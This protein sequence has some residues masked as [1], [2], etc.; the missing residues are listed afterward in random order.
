ML[1]PYWL[2]DASASGAEHGSGWRYDQE[3]RCS[4][5]A[6]AFCP[7]CTRVPRTSRTS[8]RHC[9]PCSG[10]SRREGRKAGCFRKC[11]AEPRPHCLSG[12]SGLRTFPRCPASSTSSPPRSAISGTSRC[13]PWRC[14]RGARGGGRGHPADAGPAHSPGAIA[15]AVAPCPLREPR[16]EAL[17]EILHDGRDVALVSDAGTPVSATRGRPGAAA[18]AAGITVVPIPGP[19]AVATALSAAGLKGDRYLFLGFI[20]RKG[21]ERA[22]LLARAAAE[23]WSV[24]SSRRRRGSPP[25]WKTWRRVAGRAP[26]GRGPGAHEAARGVPGGHPGGAGG[27]LFGAPPRGE[28]TIVLEGTGTPRSP[29]TAPGRPS[30]RPPYCWP[31]GSAAAR[32]S[33]ASAR[34]SASPG[35]T[36]IGW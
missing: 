1:E 19:S 2:P 36:P 16:L 31:K 10:C 5:S 4:G 34:P 9:L 11:C 8:R 22:R 21:S 27:L 7:A 6:A 30:S 12:I 33:A 13:G 25:C 32:W 3:A 29:P 20:P 14:S 24:V 28:L 23:E 15:Q 26:G 35:T 17:L 18:R